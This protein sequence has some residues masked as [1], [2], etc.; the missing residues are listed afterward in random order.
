MGKINVQG[1][2]VVEIEGETP[3]A[4]ESEEII[5]EKLMYKVWVL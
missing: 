4:Q 2:G 3:T 5:W 1:L